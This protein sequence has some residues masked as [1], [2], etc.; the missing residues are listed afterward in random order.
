M[1]ELRIGFF[2]KLKGG[3]RLILK[4]IYNIFRRPRAFFNYLTAKKVLSLFKFGNDNGFESA[5]HRLNDLL[6]GLEDGAE[7]FSFA[8]EGKSLHII[9]PGHC[10]FL[11]KLMGAE[12]RKLGISY[13]IQLKTRG[14]L[15]IPESQ[16][17]DPYIIICPQLYSGLPKHFIAVQMEQSLSKRW[18]EDPEYLNALKLAHTVLDYSLSNIEHFG[19]R[20]E[21]GGKLFYYLPLDYLSDEAPDSC[22]EE[23]E[24]DVLFYG[25]DS[26]ERRAEILKQL[27]PLFKIKIVN[28]LFGEDMLKLIRKS[29]IVLNIH[30][31]DVV[32]LETTR[33]YEVLSQNSSIII[34]E[35]S[36]DS[37][38]DSRLEG[39]V[40][41]VDIGDVEAIKARISYWLSH[42]DERRD[43][44][45]ANNEKLRSKKSD[46]SYFF[47][48]AMLANEIIDFETFYKHQKYYF[49]FEGERVCLGLIENNADRELLSKSPHGFKFFPGLRH[50]EEGKGEALSLKFLLRK[51]AEEGLERLI[52]C[53]GDILLSP[54]FEAKL[55]AL[56]T[57][58]YQEGIELISED[59]GIRVFRL[60]L[61]KS[62][63]P[64]HAK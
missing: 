9:A 50:S 23:K 54:D 22:S 46:F 47:M 35:K 28:K 10:I 26:A 13:D 17:E 7:I 24:I 32:L 19:N 61:D 59:T 49:S 53:R 33:I 44:L 31:Y 63:V 42:E 29:K 58:S 34:S 41:F 15:D 57:R 60:N 16:R 18:N 27:K 43:R 2:P 1:S 64:D 55:R 20:E 30:F 12:L 37:F 8:G 51:A 6:S 62:S 3:L 48:R 45:K 14:Y 38:E 4:L 21:F 40:D 25:D 52:V 36:A 39:I 5:E 56:L 11:T